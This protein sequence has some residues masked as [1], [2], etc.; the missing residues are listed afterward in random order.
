LLTWTDL[1]ELGLTPDAIRS[2]VAAAKLFPV[3]RGVYSL[4][5][6]LRTRSEWWMAAILSYGDGA[7][8]SH[9]SAAVLWGFARREPLGI[10]VS[11]LSPGGRR[12]RKGVTVYRRAGFGLEDV[13]KRDRIPVTTPIATLIDMAARLEG[14]PLEAMVNEAVMQNVVDLEEVRDRVE[15]LRRPGAKQLRELI[16]R[17]TFRLTRSRLER[18]FIPVVLRAGLPRPETRAF[19]NGYEVDFWWPDLEL[20]VET[21]GGN[22]HRTSRQQTK[23]R[24]REHAHIR[25]GLQCIRFTHWQVAREPE[26]VERTLVSAA[27]RAARARGRTP[28][29]RAGRRRRRS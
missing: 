12:S 5:H 28:A 14:E 25:A 1:L 19:V 4:N 22:F 29:P 7:V 16:D 8:I 18:F 27:E 24:Q 13:T 3:F 9:W 17:Q 11:F 10:E 21:D 6:R 15:R 23:D 2:R 20:V 26:H